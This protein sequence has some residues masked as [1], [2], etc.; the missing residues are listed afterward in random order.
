MSGSEGPARDMATNDPEF[1]LDEAFKMQVIIMAARSIQVHQR[2]DLMCLYKQST[3]C[4][5]VI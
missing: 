1:S 3:R 2:A 4:V 5:E